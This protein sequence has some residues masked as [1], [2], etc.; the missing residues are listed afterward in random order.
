MFVVILT[1]TKPLA[2]VDAH[3]VAHRAWLKGQ[4]EAGVFIA[5]GR[6]VPPVGGV[7]LARAESPEALR[8]VLAQDPFN[9][10]GVASYQVIEFSPSM[11]APEY[12]SLK[13]A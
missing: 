9:I 1:Y 10:N 13:G 8:V 4:Y 11:A 5:S 12:E 3:L 7:I 2:Q 6:Q